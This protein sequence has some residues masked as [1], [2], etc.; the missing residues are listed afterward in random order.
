MGVDAVIPAFLIVTVGG[1]GSFWGSVVS[2]I[3]V[4]LTAGLTGYFASDWSLMSIYILLA[5]V[6]IFRQRGLFG[7][8]SS[9]DF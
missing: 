9:L 4:G 8:A 1:V 7:K 2:G 6:L 3:A 5:V